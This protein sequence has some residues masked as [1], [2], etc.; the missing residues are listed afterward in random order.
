M[1]IP[2]SP[3]DGLFH[4]K[5]IVFRTGGRPSPWKDHLDGIIEH[6]FCWCFGTMEFYDKPNPN[7]NPCPESSTR[8]E[9]FTSQYIGNFIIPTDELIYQEGIPGKWS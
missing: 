4:G 6:V 5:S 8:R 3:L 7:Q 2:K 1:G 9:T